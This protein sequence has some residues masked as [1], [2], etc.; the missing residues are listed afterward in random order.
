M[1]ILSFNSNTS[2]NGSAPI[3]YP[4][5]K[6]LTSETYQVDLEP[7]FGKGHGMI[8]HSWTPANIT[9]NQHRNAFSPVMQERKGVKENKG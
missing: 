2:E 5:V 1:L 9:Q 8:L 7:C 3:R 4:S 6:V